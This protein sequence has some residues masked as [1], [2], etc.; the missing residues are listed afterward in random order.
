LFREGVAARIARA[1]GFVPKGE[2]IWGLRN[3]GMGGLLGN[4][5]E[6]VLIASRGRT[7]FPPNL[8]PCGVQFWRQTY[9][10]GKVHSAK[11]E[12]FLDW[13]ESVSLAPR[14]ELFARRHR[15]GWDVWGNESANTAQMPL[16]IDGEPV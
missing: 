5:H 7:A 2:V 14:V 13:V 3:H 4:G 15:L 11:P 10:I 12:G 6:P 8:L 1:W 9:G 16:V